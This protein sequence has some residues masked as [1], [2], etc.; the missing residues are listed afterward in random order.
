MNR[1]FSYF[2]TALVTFSVLVGL[3]GTPAAAYAQQPLPPSGDGLWSD[4]ADTV[5]QAAG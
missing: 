5:L 4:Y 2:L 3:A 1:F